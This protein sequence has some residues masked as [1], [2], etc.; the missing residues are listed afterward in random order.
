LD[1]SLM[2]GADRD[3]I[4]QVLSNLI[5]NALKFV[6]REGGVVTLSVG[7]DANRARFSVSDNGPGIPP[8]HLDHLFER[9][10]KGSNASRDGAGLGLFIAK[11]VVDAHGGEIRVG[12]N[13][14]HGATVQFWL[15][16]V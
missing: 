15:Q 8:E 1:P 6:P 12:N 13:G 4:L 10:W 3:R 7:A 5:G 2:V 14:T 9:Y 16:L 11:G